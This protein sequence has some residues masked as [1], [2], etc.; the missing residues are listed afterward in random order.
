MIGKYLSNT[1]T[2]SKSPAKDNRQM[3]RIALLQGRLDE[4]IQAINRLLRGQ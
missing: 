4:T 3:E 2:K 1:D